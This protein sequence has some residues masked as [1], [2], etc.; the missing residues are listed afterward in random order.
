MIIDTSIAL[1]FFMGDSKLVA[2]EEL[3]R[4]SSISQADIL[5]QE[6]ASAL[7][8]ACQLGI[9]TEPR[10]IAAMEEWTTMA[11]PSIPTYWMHTEALKWA[12]K[13]DLR[14][15]DM[16]HIL[17]AFV[18]EDVLVTLDES[19]VTRIQSTKFSPNIKLL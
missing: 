6:L 11:I 5:D 1:A 8:K 10:C 17:T 18:Q 12:F 16:L 4:S 19:L 14:P 13:L 2:I 3:L 15:V 9:A 7:A